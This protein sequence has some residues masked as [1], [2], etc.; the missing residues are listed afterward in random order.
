VDRN[1]LRRLLRVAIMRARPAI[2]GYDVIVRLKR[3][4]ARDELTAVA[5]EAEQLLRAL[6][7]Q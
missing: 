4:C 6:A 5:A 7:R 1:R 3:A 2:D